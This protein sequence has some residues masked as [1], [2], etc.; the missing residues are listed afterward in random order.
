MM[1]WKPTCPGCR[2][3]RRESTGR[4]SSR[5]NTR[6]RWTPETQVRGSGRGLAL[7]HLGQY[8]PCIQAFDRAIALDENDGITWY[9]RGIALH[10]LKHDEEALLSFD[11]VLQ[12]APSHTLAWAGKARSYAALEHYHEGHRCL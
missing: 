12:I 2:F 11:R 6:W 9:N 10:I 4:P 8:E 7:A 3:Q 5:L 1:R